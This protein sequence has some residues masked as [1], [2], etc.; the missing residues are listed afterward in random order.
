MANP[1]EW[2]PKSEPGTPVTVDDVKADP[3]SGTLVVGVF[4]TGFNDESEIIWN[5]FLYETVGL[6]GGILGATVEMPDKPET[7]TVW[8]RSGEQKSNE[9]Q[10]TWAGVPTFPDGRALPE[11]EPLI[12]RADRFRRGQAAEVARMQAEAERL[13]TAAERLQQQ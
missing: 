2:A 10:F 1:Y 12:D 5:G 8:V 4:G 9:F 13:K 11:R 7:I 3:V 6:T